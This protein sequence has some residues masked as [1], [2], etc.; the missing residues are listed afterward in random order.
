MSCPYQGEKEAVAGGYS[1]RT[2][3]WEVLVICEE[4]Q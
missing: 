2:A 3:G 1:W 4:G